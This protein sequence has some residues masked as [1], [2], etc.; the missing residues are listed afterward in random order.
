MSERVLEGIDALRDEAVRDVTDACMSAR[1]DLEARFGRRGREACAEDIHFHIE[2]VRASLEAGDK[3]LFTSYLGWVSQV[4]E[5]RG[6]PGDSL[7]VSLRALGEFF[8]SGLGADAGPITEVLEEGCAALAD[9]IEPPAYDRPCPEPWEEAD[10]FREAALAGDR[11]N[12]ARLF[13]QAL[14]RSGSLHET[15]IHVVQ[16]ALYA[17]GRLWQEN[18]VSVA[19]EHM[20]SAIAQTLM[21]QGYGVVEPA[22]NIDRTA[23]FA[24]PAGNQHAIGL[25]MVADA[26]EQVGWTVHFLGADTPL[27]A[28][29]QHIRELAPDLVGLSASLPGH[30]KGVR[31]AVSGL[32]RALGKECPRIVVGGLVFN[33]FPP[34]A[35]RLGVDILGTDAA[36]SVASLDAC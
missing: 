14:Q 33:Q 11:E 9:G 1:P 6:V 35:D 30:L 8:A 5:T 29:V 3:S 17:I 20:A 15:E 21:G 34:L 13:T 22:G 32:R 16:P 18:K 2:F 26:F 4:L 24:C 10:A 25:R 23:V 27:A 19:Q 28:L 36:N 7:M 12:A 31:E